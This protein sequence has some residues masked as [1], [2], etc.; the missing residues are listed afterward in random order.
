MAA[1]GGS[2][3]KGMQEFEAGLKTGVAV[4][5]SS[6]FLLSSA[7]NLN[8]SCSFQQA[9]NGV[10]LQAREGQ[11]A[12]PPLLAGW[13]GMGATHTVR[14]GDTQPRHCGGW[15]TGDRWLQVNL[16]V[17]LERKAWGSWSHCSWTWAATLLPRQALWSGDSLAK[18]L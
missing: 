15:L 6:S 14:Q 17:L 18:R 3:G 12:G 2:R 10:L 1:R 13:F 7:V 9:A 11:R 5:L 8:Y 4:K 16:A